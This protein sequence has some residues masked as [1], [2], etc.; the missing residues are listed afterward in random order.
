MSDISE[1][2]EEGREDMK[3][4]DNPSLVMIDEETGNKY[5]RMVDQT[6]LGKEGE[7]SWVIKDMHEELK[8]WGRPGG[9]DNKMIVKS[10]GESPIVAV[11]EAFAEKHGAWR[12]LNRALK[13]NMPLTA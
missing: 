8:A 1:S 2:E 5:M 9:G 13:E 4:S 10:D 3:A 12:H 7:M 6:G 11:C